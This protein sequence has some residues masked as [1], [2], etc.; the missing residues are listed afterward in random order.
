[1]CDLLLVTREGIQR[2][3]T[4]GERL[5]VA[6]RRR[7]GLNDGNEQLNLLALHRHDLYR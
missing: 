2:V 5:F 1:M 7:V 6:E 3:S 4:E